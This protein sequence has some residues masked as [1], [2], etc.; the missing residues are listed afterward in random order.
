M[1]Y[2]P[3]PSRRSVADDESGGVRLVPVP[4]GTVVLPLSGDGRPSV[5]S[6]AGRLA[7]TPPGSARQPPAASAGLEVA[8]PGLLDLDGLE[9]C[10]EVADAEATT[11]VALDDLEEERR[12][13][14]DRSGEDLEEVALLIA[15]GLDAELL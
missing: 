4:D 5:G 13:I 3:D 14:L 2:R 7:G 8:A 12:P 10:L 1:Q 15:I 6:G 11:A 9:Q